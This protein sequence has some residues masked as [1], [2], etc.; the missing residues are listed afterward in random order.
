M[1]HTRTLSVRRSRLEGSHHDP[2]VAPT[3]TSH[4]LLR[5]QVGG[6]D[7]VCVDVCVRHRRRTCAENGCSTYSSTSITINPTVPATMY[8]GAKL[9]TPAP[10]L[11]VSVFLESVLSLGVQ[12]VP[13]PSPVPLVLKSAAVGRVYLLFRSS[14]VEII[15]DAV[16]GT[17]LDP[18]LASELPWDSTTQL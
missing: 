12:L 7:T 15:S 6:P 5:N 18:V 9:D 11:T 2:S 1:H 13:A 10:L 8:K 3:L 17:A 16:A 14:S 4:D